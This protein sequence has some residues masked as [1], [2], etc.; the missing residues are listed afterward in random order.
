LTQE[1]QKS[2]FFDRGGAVRKYSCFAVVLAIGWVP[3]L[4]QAPSPKTNQVTESALPP[5]EAWNLLRSADVSIVTRV[6]GLPKNVRSALAHAFHQAELEMG[7]PDHEVKRRCADCV[8]VRLIFAG[9][10]SD[11]CFVHYS[12]IGLGAS[13]NIIVFDTTAEKGAR[14]IWAARGIPASNL[15]KLRSS[16]AEGKFRPFPP[17]P[18]L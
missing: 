3:A 10:S 8:G 4:G 7:D 13:F 17:F 1:N 9:V 14:P 6:D 2:T 11:G 15:D 5:V 16:I 12:A 18:I